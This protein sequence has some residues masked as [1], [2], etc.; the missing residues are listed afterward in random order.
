[1]VRRLSE[2]TVALG[3]IFRL[4]LCSREDVSFNIICL[5]MF[6][7]IKQFYLL[8]WFKNNGLETPFK[9]DNVKAL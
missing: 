4:V 3:F 9:G 6:E 1:M 5:N 2:I 8:M 7:G